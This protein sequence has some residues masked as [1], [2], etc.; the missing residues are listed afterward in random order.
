MNRCM[1]LE[2]GMCMETYMILSDWLSSPPATA[3]AGGCMAVGIA[4]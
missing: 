2:K 4:K 3:P 1:R